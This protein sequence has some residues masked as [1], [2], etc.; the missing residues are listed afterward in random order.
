[1]LQLIRGFFLRIH[2]SN[3]SLLSFESIQCIIYDINYGW[4]FRLLHFNGANL[5][6]IFLYMHFFK[7]LFYRGYLLKK[8]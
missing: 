3:D 4:F 8:V 7:S 5:F 6:F 1:M 2:Y